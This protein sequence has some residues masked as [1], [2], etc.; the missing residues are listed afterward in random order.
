MPDAITTLLEDLAPDTLIA[1]PGA[2]DET[3]TFVA[4]GSALTLTNTRIS[5]KRRMVRDQLGREVVSSV[6]AIVLEL[7]S[8]TVEGF[9]YTLPSNRPE[10]RTNL[11]ALA[12]RIVPDENGPHHEVVEFP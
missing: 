12:V 10:P 5:G 2:E 9:R 3:G 11:K 8:L 6:H 4:A 7:N 1:Q